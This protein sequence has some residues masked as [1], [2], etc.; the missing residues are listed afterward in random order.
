MQAEG[1]GLLA[2]KRRFFLYNRLSVYTEQSLVKLA[3]AVLAHNEEKGIEETLQGLLQQSVFAK[4]PLGVEITVFVIA[5]GCTDDTVAISKRA[6]S[7]LE[8]QHDFRWQVVDLEG[9]GKANAWNFFVHDLLSVDVD[10]AAIMD[11]DIGFGERDTITKCIR[12]LE[13][14][15]RQMVATPLLVKY[16]PKGQSS[17]I[18]KLFVKAFSGTADSTFH[19]IAGAFYCARA[20]ALKEVFMPHGI[21]IEDGFL[22]AMI[23]TSGLT[24]PE[25]YERIQ[26]PPEAT[27]CHVPYTRLSEI[28]RYQVRQAK[29]T[30]INLFIYDEL[31]QLPRSFRARM[32]EVQTRNRTNPEWVMRLVRGMASHSR[33]LIPKDYTFRRIANLRTKSGLARI[34]CLLLLPTLL[35]D[36][37]VAQVAHRTLKESASDVQ[38]DRIRD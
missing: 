7:Q 3:I 24:T 1:I 2:Y 34:K 13:A 37:R 11:A 33:Q 4:D 35:F 31:D 17:Q 9:A 26:T 12:M 22:R 14:S 6:L 8:A 25:E 23:L 16:F 20:A 32:E 21:V 28:F 18:G 27:V 19:T 5:N 10:Y 36:L 30:A 29:G 38:W 15:P